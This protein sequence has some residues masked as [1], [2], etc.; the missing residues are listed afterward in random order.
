MSDRHKA[1]QE[2]H[3]VAR[4]VARWSRVH[5]RRIAEVGRDYRVKLKRQ[6]RWEA[7]R[8]GVLR[9]RAAT[10]LGRRPEAGLLFL[11]D[12]Q[13]AR[14]AGAPVPPP[15]GMGGWRAHPDAA[16]RRSPRWGG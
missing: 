6:P 3:H 5:V 4:D 7:D 9:Q 14:A 11:A 15:R 8:L 10:L 2:I 16:E 12:L 1:D 13:I